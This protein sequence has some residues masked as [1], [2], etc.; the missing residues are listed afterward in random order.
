MHDNTLVSIKTSVR[1]V[2]RYMA[3]A[4]FHWQIVILYDNVVMECQP[5]MKPLIED[6][7]T[8]KFQ[9]NLHL[10]IKC[11]MYQQEYQFMI[12]CTCMGLIIN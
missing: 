8:N 11:V 10:C 2:V 9:C 1:F 4:I 7:K 6:D 3:G 12:R 5:W